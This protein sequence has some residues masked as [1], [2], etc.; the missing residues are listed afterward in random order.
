MNLGRTLLLWSSVLNSF[1]MSLRQF[2]FLRPWSFPLDLFRSKWGR[3]QRTH[4]GTRLQVPAYGVTLRPGP[5]QLLGTRGHCREDDSVVSRSSTPSDG[6]KVRKDQQPFS[7][8]WYCQTKDPI[9]TSGYRTS[10]DSG[11]DQQGREDPRLRG[12]ARQTKNRVRE[13][14]GKSGETPEKERHVGRPMWGTK[15]TF[16]YDEKS[17]SE[18]EPKAV[19]R[20]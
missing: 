2:T 1:P 12:P 6:Q 3:G 7:W 13:S 9:A 10:V 18:F 17:Q 16:S 8:D 11:E 15:L 14:Q 20:G 4:R 5:Y 19:L